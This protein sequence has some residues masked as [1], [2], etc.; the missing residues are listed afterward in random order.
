MKR[1]DQQQFLRHMVRIEWT[2]AVKLLNHFGSNSLGLEIFRSA[3][4]DAMPDRCQ[5]ITLAAF[6]NPI[7]QSAHRRSVILR[8]HQT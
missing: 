5:C 4:H 8:L 1:F 6:V 7:H 3:M 2:Q